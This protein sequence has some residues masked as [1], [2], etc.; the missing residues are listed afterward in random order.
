[1]VQSSRNH[2]LSSYLVFFAWMIQV[3]YGAPC[4]FMSSA[5]SSSL[6]KGAINC[7]N[8]AFLTY[9]VLSLFLIFSTNSLSIF[10]TSFTVKICA[11]HTR[12]Y[13]YSLAPRRRIA[14]MKPSASH[15]TFK[16]C[17]A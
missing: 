3:T 7:M 14:G 2:F 1:M 12:A 4:P 15:Y 9:P 13:V 6:V 5:L 11:A 10:C 16:N 8:S 17:A